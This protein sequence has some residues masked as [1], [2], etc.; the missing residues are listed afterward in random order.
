MTAGASGQEL[1]S[2]GFPDDVGIATELDAFDV[3][4]VVTNEGT[5][6]G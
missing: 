4:P 6:A 2:G 1:I 3:V 5:A